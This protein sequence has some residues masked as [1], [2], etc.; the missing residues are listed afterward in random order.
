MAGIPERVPDVHVVTRRDNPC[1][2]R[3]NL[4][5]R[6][7]L[8]KG[9]A[10]VPMPESGTLSFLE[11]G[12]YSY[13][14]DNSDPVRESITE[15]APFQQLRSVRYRF[16]ASDEQELVLEKS[17]RRDAFWDQLIAVDESQLGS[18]P[19]YQ[20]QEAG[21]FGAVLSEEV[22]AIDY[23]GD[24]LADHKARLDDPI[25]P[26]QS[27]Q[28]VSWK[29]L[30]RA[31]WPLDFQKILLAGLNDSSPTF[32]Y[33]N[34]QWFTTW[35]SA[36]LPGSGKEDHWFAP[37]LLIDG[38]LI[39]PA[40]L[41]AKTAFVENSEGTTLPIWTLE[42]SHQGTTVRQE[43]FSLRSCSFVRFQLEGET[44][45]IRLAIGTGR[46]PNNHYWDDPKAARTPI[47]FFTTPAE[48]RREG[49]RV[50]NQWNRTTLL[51]GQAFVLE[52]LGPVEHVLLFDPDEDGRVT[53]FTPQSEAVID[54]PDYD[55]ARAECVASWTSR[56]GT[57]AQIR[58]PSNEWQSRVDAWRYQIEA[59]TRVTYHGP[60]SNATQTTRERLSYGAC[61]YLDYFGIEEAW[62]VVAFAMLGRGEEAKHQAEM[63]LDPEAL[64]KEEVHHQYRNGLAGITAST[65][66]M[67][68]RDPVWL[69]KIA[70]TLIE[71]ANWTERVCGETMNASNPATR[72]LLPPHIYGGDLRDPATSL[73]STMTCWRGLCETAQAFRSLGSPEL[74]KEG[75]RIAMV[76]DRL[77]GQIEKTL[78]A[79]TDHST[80]PPFVPLAL[81]LPSLDGRNEGPHEDLTA[82]R[83]GNFWILFAP[84]F[85]EL[86]F[87]STVQPQTNEWIYDYAKTHGGL[88]AGLPRFATGIDAAYAIG[89]I[90]YLVNRSI[91]E[92]DFR[93]EAISCLHAFMLHASS[94]NGH[95][96]PEVAGLFPYRLQRD[97]YEAL[98]RESPW[99][100]GMYDG[101][102]YLDG[103]IS[104]TEPLGAGAGEVLWLIRSMLITES[105]DDRGELDRSLMVLAA[106]PSDWL[107]EG[108]EIALRDCPTYYGHLSIVIR[109][110]IGSRNE[111][112]IEHHFTPYDSQEDSDMALERIR[113]RLV[114]TGREAKEV[115][116]RPVESQ[117]TVVDFE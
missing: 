98:V 105:R 5:Q 92:I 47:P 88:W 1:L 17:S 106:A 70:P 95:T 96:I 22:R 79:V 100:F 30:E 97:A 21:D 32:A 14:P 93:P 9:R 67:L 87:R 86:D 111:I 24:E 50:I 90:S 10:T 39:R 80:T 77:H 83:F 20:L 65:V 109:S 53:L 12:A 112:T 116:L 117:Q 8:E 3:L 110:A 41:S 26:F 76:A 58:V 19:R 31:A 29:E 45:R 73:Y 104:F 4:L 101:E 6:L 99:S 7:L 51:S 82:T 37:A 44:E 69:A 23:S 74:V 68:T 102:R 55:Q 15:I 61:F 25:I 114:P 54:L 91:H 35:K 2:T 115:V 36:D 60:A 89:Y 64:N 85:L 107:D 59:I 84:M 43:I 46:R 18:L 49:N 103:H 34:G 13:G 42:W 40:P 27:K 11:F 81:D 38:K 108:K 94:S 66:A 71:C 52:P 28:E 48:I 75:E 57:G 78:C 113:V 56:L 33:Q 16:P 63:M 72:G 62:A